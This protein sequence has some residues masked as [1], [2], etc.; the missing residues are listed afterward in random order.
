MTP[1]DTLGGLKNP[2]PLTG[3]GVPHLRIPQIVIFSLGGFR[4]YPQNS[5]SSKR[6][7]TRNQFGSI[8]KKL[9]MPYED[10]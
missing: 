2:T 1:L 10:A 5:R 3:I 8:P 6:K 4:I 7:N 9:Q